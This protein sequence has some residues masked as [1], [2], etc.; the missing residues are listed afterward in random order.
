MYNFGVC[1]QTLIPVR[2]SNTE[3][4]EMVTQII[5]GET[6][7]IKEN[8]GNWSKV[9]LSYDNYE[10]WIDIKFVSKID[11]KQYDKINNNNVVDRLF[12]YL[13]NITTS[14]KIPL[15][16]GS[17]L[18]NIDN[19]GY[20]NINDTQFQYS[21]NLNTE[22][23]I[24]IVAKQFLN[25]PYL[26]GGKTIL[27]IDCSGFSQIVYKIMGIKLQRDASMQEKQGATVDSIDDAKVGDLAFFNNQEG[28]VTHVGIILDKYKIIHASGWVRVDTID[29]N[30]I[31]NTTTNEYSHKLYS[32]KRFL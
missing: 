1:L 14:E 18:P 30:G 13:I 21:D 32:I 22:K 19:R 9:I 24:E 23:S 8:R 16:A 11:K 4:S 15:V 10:G 28:K 27:G 6:Y 31:L 29:E 3:T 26:W 2:V 17:N 25:A 5:F 7:I 20:F 12:S